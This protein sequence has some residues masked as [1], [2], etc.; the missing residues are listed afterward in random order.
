MKVLRD[1]EIELKD[2]P[3]SP[4]S[5]RLART[6][7]DDTRRLLDIIKGDRE[8]YEDNIKEI[9]QEIQ[10]LGSSPRTRSLTMKGYDVRSEIKEFERNCMMVISEQSNTAKVISK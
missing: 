4:G 9:N 10:K 6:L 7:E 2:D 8:I 5:M 3:D 1:R